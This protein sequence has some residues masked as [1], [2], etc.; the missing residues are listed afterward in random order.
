MSESNSNW[1]KFKILDWLQNKFCNYIKSIKGV[2]WHSFIFQI[3][4]LSKFKMFLLSSG[5]ISTEVYSHMQHM[6]MKIARSE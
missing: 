4:S 5:M 2:S 1:W 6:K 3:N